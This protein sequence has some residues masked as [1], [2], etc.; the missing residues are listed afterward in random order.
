MSQDEAGRSYGHSFSNW[1]ASGSAENL[2]IRKCCFIRCFCSSFTTFH[3]FS[4]LFIACHTCKIW[5]QICH[6][7]SYIKTPGI[8]A[9]LVLTYIE[10]YW[11]AFRGP[12]LQSGGQFH[13]RGMGLRRYVIHI[14][15]YMMH[16]CH[17]ISYPACRCIFTRIVQSKK[18]ASKS[19]K[20]GRK[21][22][23]DF[24]GRT[25]GVLLDKYPLV[26]KHCNLKSPINGGFSRKVTYIYG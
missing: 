12:N 6:P 3:H 18:T 2:M 11:N 14:Y 26:I 20:R 16:A 7:L 10:N 15:I 9:R 1:R 13:T 23:T 24:H 17:V 22:P 4:W 5:P 25:C 8:N 21:D 19:C